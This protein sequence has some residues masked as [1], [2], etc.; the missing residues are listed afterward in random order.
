MRNLLG[1]GII[2]A[3]V[4]CSCSDDFVRPR[5][6]PGIIDMTEAPKPGSGSGDH[7]AGSK[8]P[9]PDSDDDDSKG[10][11]DDDD[12]ADA[13]SAPQCRSCDDR[14]P[15]TR[16]TRS[17][18]RGDCDS[19]CSHTEITRAR[20]GDRCC[21]A[22][23]SAADDSDCAAV[24]G[25]G[26]LDPGEDCDGG[27]SCSDDC[28][29]LMDSSLIHRYSF[30][31]RGTAIT[32]SVGDADGRLVNGTLADDGELALAG[33]PTNAY[34]D[35][36]DGLISGL[37]SVTIETW[38]RWS[39]GA[40]RQR[41]FDFGMNSAGEDRTGRGTSF[42]MLEPNSSNNRLATY[43]NFTATADD[44]SANRYVEAPSRLSTTMH[45]IAVT[46]DA[47]SATLRLYLDGEL[48]GRSATGTASLSQIDDRN[49]WLGRAN[50]DE[51]YFQGT[52]YEFRIYDTAL[53]DAAIAASNEAG[54]DAT[55]AR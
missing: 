29:L 16:D 24:C 33:A 14:D 11:A 50:Y 37:Q 4:L 27:E 23:M 31:G 18:Q 53:D 5:P 15:C 6:I 1:F 7:D 8:P 54:P 30:D 45:Q 19:Q 40:V 22:G 49:A 48:Q 36:P 44:T 32:D 46:F 20:D 55:T 25:N 26:R 42:L 47:T 52:L 2:F 41:I 3:V 43:A 21:P 28:T 17:S 39:G 34:V 12:A 38:V 9:R 51:P 35:L 13:G 10:D